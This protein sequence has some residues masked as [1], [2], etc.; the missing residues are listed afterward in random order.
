MPQ[1]E[2]KPTFFN[3]GVAIDIGT[4]TVAAR[5]YN[6]RGTLLSETTCLNPQSRW[7]ADA[8]S[9]INASLNG[10]RH[11]LSQTI[12]NALN[13]MI[14]EISSA[15]NIST[16]TIDGVCIVGNTVMLSLLTEESVEPFSHAP[17]DVKRLFG[18][19]LTVKELS[20]SA[21]EPGT[22][23]YLPPLYIAGGFG[24]YLNKESAAKI[25]LSPK[26]LV[27]SSHTVGNAALGGAAMLLLN[28]NV[29]VKVEYMSKNANVLDLS[30][31]VVFSEYYMKGMTLSEV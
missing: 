12:R 6:S 31:S 20:L 17:F 10:K 7:G 27:K 14:T 3:Y 11:L 2:C 25:G 9:R 13:D 30:T 24:N 5:L 21:L 8:V 29:R 19:T 23:I 18:E 22:S 15:A 28:S 1:F 4:T 26:A 16:K